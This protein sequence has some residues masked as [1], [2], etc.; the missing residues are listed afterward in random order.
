MGDGNGRD[1]T[2][3]RGKGSG[4]GDSTLFPREALPR[5]PPPGLPG[6][7]LSWGTAVRATSR[8]A[9]SIS[10]LRDAP[11]GRGRGGRRRSG[12]RGAKR[13]RRDGQTEARGRPRGWGRGGKKGGRKGA[14]GNGGGNN[15]VRTAP[16][17]FR[18]RT[19]PPRVDFGASR[20]G[21]PDAGSGPRAPRAL[22]R[23]GSGGHRL[24]GAEEVLAGGR[25]RRR[26]GRADA[27]LGPR[28]SRTPRPGAGWGQSGRAAAGSAAAA[29]LGS[30][31]A[32]QGGS[33]QA[34]LEEA[35]SG[36]SARGSAP[37]RGSPPD[38]WRGVGRRSGSRRAAPS[39][40]R[41]GHGG[42]CVPHALPPPA[43]PRRGLAKDPR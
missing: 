10:G 26:R 25:P 3:T 34:R 16:A 33:A 8:R 35:R 32:P 17:Q 23:G 6:T 36:S 22:R 38:V 43:S 37:A 9:G 11:W 39:A 40:G 29:E 24:A 27:P 31:G 4:M 15:V 21:Q 14:G 20:P 42:R 41:L 19:P 30:P 12:A 28:L 2:S 13:G 7:H 1:G 5:P 18:F